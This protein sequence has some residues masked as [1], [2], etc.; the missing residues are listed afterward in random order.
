MCG[1]HFKS[2]SMVFGAP[3]T[4][5]LQ[6]LA[7]KYSANSAP[8]VFESS[9]PMTTRPSKSMPLQTSNEFLNCS[10][11]SILCRPLPSM[12]N[13][14]VLRNESIMS[15]VISTN[16]PVKIPCGP[17]KNPII[18]ESG[19]Q[20]LTP[21]KMPAITL[22]PPGA[23][24]PDNTTPTLIGE[25]LWPLGVPAA[26]STK[27][28]SYVLGNSPFMVSASFAEA[29]TASFFTATGHP[30]RTVGRYSLQS[31]RSLSFC[32]GL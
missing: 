2:P 9:P 29:G 14:P 15:F 12:S 32:N 27:G 8:L 3:T 10:S 23:C 22:C 19:C 7:L 11:V 6:P 18:V 4:L 28:M 16:V 17:S 5:V 20:F 26:N 31:A 1:G 24:P 30:S 21:S 13:P 25:L